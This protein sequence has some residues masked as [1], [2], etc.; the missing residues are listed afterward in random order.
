MSKIS[1]FVACYNYGRFLEKCLQSILSQ[2]RKAD[3][4]LVIDDCSTDN[5]PEIAKRFKKKITYI[6]HPKNLGSS[7]TFNIGP[8]LAKGDY[9]LAISADDWLAPTMLEKEAAILDKNRKVGLVYSLAYQVQNQKK[10]LI[11]PGNLPTKSYI[12][13]KEDFELLLTR[14]CFIPA[15]TAMVRRSVYQKLGYWD[16]NLRHA[17]D[18]EM[19]TRI[20]KYYPLAYLAQP[21]AYYR[22]HKKSLT[23]IG[24]WPKHLEY[25]H[26]YI[27]KKHLKSAPIHLKETA[28]FNYYTRLVQNSLNLGKPIDAAKFLTKALKLN[29]VKTLKLSFKVASV[30]QFAKFLK[31]LKNGIN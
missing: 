31:D 21:L 11:L 24:Q 17:Q 2:T 7:K 27:L 13:R 22:I 20:A 16:V 3:E 28:Y 10:R 18:F 30:N 9:I 29:P 8:K 4:I 5:T 15:Q 12:A 25:E 23:S 19:W 14:G 6:R 1:V 26:G